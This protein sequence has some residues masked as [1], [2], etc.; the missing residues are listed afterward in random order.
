MDC[1]SIRQQAPRGTSR[2][3]RRAI[4]FA[5]CRYRQHPPPPPS[6][7]I[8]FPNAS[9]SRWITNLSITSLSYLPSRG[10]ITGSDV[11]SVERVFFRPTHTLQDFPKNGRGRLFF[12]RASIDSKTM[13]QWEEESSRCVKNRED[14]SM[15]REGV[16]TPFLSSPFPWKAESVR[17]KPIPPRGSSISVLQARSVG[18]S[19]GRGFSLFNP[20]R[21]SRCAVYR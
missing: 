15:E 2:I 3:E 7:N 19:A 14:P 8:S 21:R 4:S 16:R 6:Q 12:E 13:G 20:R 9:S 1:G 11:P 18:G 17:N 10:G 5:D